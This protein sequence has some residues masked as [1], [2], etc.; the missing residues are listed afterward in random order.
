MTTTNG[1][2]LSR[3]KVLAG[4]G[5]IGVGSAGAGLGTTAYFT[6]EESFENNVLTAGELDLRIDWQQQYFG[7]PENR[8][9]YAPYGSAGYPYVNAHP[10]HDGDGEQ[11]L[12]LGDFDQGTFAEHDD[13]VRYT[14]TEGGANIQ[15]Y[16]TCETLANFGPADFDNDNR[17]Q[18]SLIELDDVKPGD[19]GEVTFSYHLCDNPGYVWLTGELDAID[20][21]LADAI[22]VR[23]WYDLACDNEVREEDKLIFEWGSLSDV[24]G[25]LS[26]GSVQLNPVVYE[27]GFILNGDE[28]GPG[29][30]P[31]LGK[32]EWDDDAKR[33]TVE[34]D[35]RALSESDVEAINDTLSANYEYN[36]VLEYDLDDGAVQIG[37]VI[38]ETDDDGDPLKID[39]ELI[40]GISGEPV[41][42][43]CLFEV[44]AGPTTRTFTPGFCVTGGTNVQVT[45]TDP[46]T[47]PSIS[48]V[49]FYYCPEDDEE[50]PVCFPA[51]ETYCIGFE[52]C[53]PVDVDVDQI[54]GIDDIN[55]LQATAA[56]FDIGFYTEQCRHNDEPSGPAS[57][58]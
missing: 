35:G 3:R 26:D 40:G 21:E 57:D 4:L 9:G 5:A 18:E 41:D 52:W 33:F 37:I 31:K 17:T 54:D 58:D 28:G 14:D 46:P 16:L 42:G 53:L 24:F 56:A 23:V 34:E 10:D 19:C 6:D 50:P 13:V 11:S 29:Y 47:N 8:E 15:D 1:F 39:F 44:K 12:D 32:M 38:R 27:E 45:R 36:D 2:E 7:P 20:Q 51:D 43:F 48:N 22:D 25:H 30:C 55:D 49:T